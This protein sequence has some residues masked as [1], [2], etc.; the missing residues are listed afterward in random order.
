MRI[1]FIAP[2][3]LINQAIER[4]LSE[5]GFEVELQEWPNIAQNGFSDLNS[6]Y[7]LTLMDIDAQTLSQTNLLQFINERN[8]PGKYIAVHNGWDE[9]ELQPVLD[10]GFH[11]HD[12]PGYPNQRMDTAP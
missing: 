8:L 3:T 10:S 6:S 4:A 5:N 1:L 2:S 9:G 7:D 12:L 11:D